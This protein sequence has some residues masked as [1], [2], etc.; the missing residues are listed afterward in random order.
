MFQIPDSK[1][2]HFDFLQKFA[3]NSKIMGII[4]ILLGLVG[5]IFPTF[6]SV[7]SAIFFGWILLFSG[8]MAGYFT[9]NTNRSDW[10]GWLK[11]FVL[12]FFGAL[13]IINPM[14]GV[15]AL[16][17]LFAIYFAMDAFA[18]FALAGSMKGQS[19]FW[20]VI[21]NGIISAILSFLFILDWPFGSLIYVGLFV[22]IS[23]FFDGIMLL[24]MSNVFKKLDEQ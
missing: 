22:G 18:S 1:S 10:L 11:A 15:A 2:A 24:T 23:L 19:G 5:I 6:M 13:I 16:G 17:I 8:F 21:L 4:F 3:K 14:P 7:T 12:V 20:I 9:Y